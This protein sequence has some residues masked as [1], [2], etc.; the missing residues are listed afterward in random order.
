MEIKIND[1]H[2]SLGD[3][4]REA[5]EDT[6]TKLERYSPRPVQSIKLTVVYEAG[7]FNADG[8][9]YLKNNEFR[10][11]G[12]GVEPE[13]A[14]AEIEENLR[15]QLSKFKGKIS[16]RQKGEEGGLGRAMVDEVGGPLDAEAGGTGF[17]LQTLDVD[18]AKAR[19]GESDLP[20]LVF[21]NVDTARVGVIYRN[22]QGELTH[23][24]YRDQS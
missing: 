14:V 15:K 5:L 9:L 23:M 16:G 13:I 8:V 7:R 18:R 10:A 1:R 3:E 4:Q 19:F 2:F 12:E 6:L 20:F 17:V 21:R 22:A 11:K 24:E